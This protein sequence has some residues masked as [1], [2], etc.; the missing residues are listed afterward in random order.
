[1]NK[2]EFE[3]LWDKGFDAHH[4]PQ[5]IVTLLKNFN[6]AINGLY[7][8]GGEE[9]Y[10]FN[11]LDTSAPVMREYERLIQSLGISLIEV[12]DTL[13]KMRSILFGDCLDWDNIY[14]EFENFYQTSPNFKI[15]NRHRRS[16]R[17]TRI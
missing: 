5:E 12:A 13:E 15:R 10:I 7:A 17:Y 3:K 14:K 9:Q 8:I 6:D 11:V 16:T 1:M 4:D 2:E